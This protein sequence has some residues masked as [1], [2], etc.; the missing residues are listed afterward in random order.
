MP[1][2]RRNSSSPSCSSGYTPSDTYSS[3]HSHTSSL[4]SYTPLTEQLDYFDVQDVSENSSHGRASPPLSGLDPLD[5]DSASNE[6]SPIA[7]I[8][9][10]CRLPGNVS[11]PA[12]FWEL[13]ARARSGYSSVPPN[14]FNHDAYYHP[15]PGKPG[16]YHATGG[17]FLQDDIAA[18]DAPF[19]GLTENE[20]LAMDPQQ[21]LLLECTFEALENAGIPKHSIVGRDVGVFIGGS[22]AEY[23]THLSRDSDIIAMHQATGKVLLVQLSQ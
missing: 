2:I 4:S 1:G 3:R 16:S 21:R 17:Y 6:S 11:S 12:E 14:R 20:A 19:F 8:G 15:N 10:A 23:E 5:E 18:F 9:M 7:I 13:C 22:L